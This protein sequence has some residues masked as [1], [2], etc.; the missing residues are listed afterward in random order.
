M[1]YYELLEIEV[2]ATTTQIK[3]AYRKK[4]KEHHPDHGGD[5]E[6]FKTIKEAYDCLMNNDERAFYDRVGTSKA[7]DLMQKVTTLISEAINNPNPI[8]TLLNTLHK[9]RADCNIRIRQ[10]DD[11]TSKLNNRLESFKLNSEHKLYP[12]FVGVVNAELASIAEQKKSFEDG[13]REIA[14]LEMMFSGLQDPES[15]S[16]NTSHKSVI[17]QS[18]HGHITEVNNLFAQFPYKDS[19][20]E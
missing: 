15:K 9:A 5:P 18:K 4:A 1:N 20:N 16:C 8:K 12:V 10:F 19:D 6:I 14:Q 11:H 2:T 3:A 13:L 7:S 17:F